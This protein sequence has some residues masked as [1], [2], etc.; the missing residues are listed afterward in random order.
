MLEAGVEHFR[1]YTGEL[2]VELANEVPVQA[3]PEKQ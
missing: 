1:N 3:E 2:L